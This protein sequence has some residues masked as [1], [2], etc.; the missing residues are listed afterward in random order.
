MRF[1]IKILY[2]IDSVNEWMG[3]IFGSL[4]L[5]LMGVVIYDTLM[6]YVFNSP[7]IWG[8]DV[9]KI[10]LLAVVCLGGGY[11]LL[12][13]GHVRVDIVYLLFPRRI[14]AVFDTFTYL[15]V[16]AFCF[17]VVKYGGYLFLEAFRIGETSSDS[18]WEYLM[19]PVLLLIPVAGGLL[20]A[21]AL[22]KWIRDLVMVIAGKDALQSEVVKGEGGLRG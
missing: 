15:F 3:K 11:C 17:V 12:H 10:L 16:L 21:Q 6:R 7:T 22:A 13:G 2:V 19:W 20:G 8:M 18:A 5:I 1:L 14:R 4:I 9:N